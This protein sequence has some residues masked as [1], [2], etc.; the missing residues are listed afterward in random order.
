MKAQIDKRSYLCTCCHILSLFE[1]KQVNRRCLKSITG[2]G[3]GRH[4]WSCISTFLLKS[5]LLGKICRIYFIIDFQSSFLRNKLEHKK[6]YDFLLYEFTNKLQIWMK[7]YLND[8]DSK[9]N[10]IILLFSIVR[11]NQRI[12]MIL[13]H[14]WNNVPAILAIPWIW[15]KCN[16][17]QK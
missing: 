3:L 10:V 16:D 2:T 15:N 8:V 7:A 12:F 6:Y 11:Y 13:K 4:L 1:I 14:K 17:C 5:G 9:T